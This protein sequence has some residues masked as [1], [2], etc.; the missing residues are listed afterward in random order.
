[1]MDRVKRGSQCDRWKIRVS[2]RVGGSM[3]KKAY[4]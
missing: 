4:K 3:E 2:G 1:M